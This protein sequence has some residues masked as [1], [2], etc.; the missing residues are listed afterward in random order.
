MVN[1]APAPVWGQELFYYMGKLISVAIFGLIIFLLD[2]YMFGA[3]RLLTENSSSNVKRWVFIIYWGISA[4]TIVLMAVYNLTNI[5]EQVPELRQWILFWLVA[6]TISKVIGGFFLVLD[7]I[8]RLF[9]W[10]WRKLVINVEA[11]SSAPA[12]PVTPAGITRSEF[13]AK[14]A[15]VA[16]AVPMVT[17]GFGILSGAHD[18]RVRHRRV[19]LPNLPKA[20]NGF[21][22]A[23]L[24]DI[25][26]GSF[27]NK[28]AVAGGVQMLLEQKPDAIFFTGDLVNNMTSEVRDYVPIFSKLNAPFGV[29]STLG[30]HDYGEYIPWPSQEAKRQNLLNMVKVHKQMGW[31]LL[32]NENRRFRTGGEEIAV[33]GVENWGTGRWP[34]YGRLEQAYAGIQDLPVK[35]LLSHDPTHWDGQVRP[36]YPDIDIT[37]S[38]HTHGFQFGIEIGD[39][40]WSPASWMYKQWAD[41]YQEGNQYLYVNRGYGYLGFPG[42]VG[43]LPEITILEL[44]SS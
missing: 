8:W 22:I 42:R 33:L 7:D 23:Q 10:C 30:N 31:D 13:L 18:Y 24:S 15:L 32:M 9:M 37:F 5:R 39:F 20:F 38:G 40:R 34:K 29:Y 35:L 26:S 2:L 36:L 6:Y 11:P 25:H 16:T 4:F 19:V 14:T 12:Q 3:I 28:T 27:F 21:K 1:K 43:I 41:L 17:M 44:V